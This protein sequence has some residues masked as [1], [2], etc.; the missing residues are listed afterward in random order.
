MGANTALNQ[1]A[2]QSEFEA[3]YF[4]L[5]GSTADV[6]IR[7]TEIKLLDGIR[8]LRLRQI[9]V[10]VLQWTIETC[11]NISSRATGQEARGFRQLENF[12]FSR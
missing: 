4:I 2:N 5:A 3:H 12:S 7:L 6:Y 8:K 10:V 11:T 9:Y 1:S